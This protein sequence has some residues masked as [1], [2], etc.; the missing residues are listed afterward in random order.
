MIAQSPTSA[1]ENPEIIAKM[2]SKGLSDSL[3]CQA[4]RWFRCPAADEREETV[5][6]KSHHRGGV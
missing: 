2:H 4:K 3:T 1:T 5:R 6:G